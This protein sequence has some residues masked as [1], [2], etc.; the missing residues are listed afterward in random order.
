[1]II[2]AAFA[3]EPGVGLIA[4]RQGGG[5]PGRIRRI[6]RGYH[7]TLTGPRAFWALAP[8]WPSRDGGIGGESIRIII[9]WRIGRRELDCLLALWWKRMGA[10]RDSASGHT[11]YVEFSRPVLTELSFPPL[12]PSAAHMGVTC[13]CAAVQRPLDFTNRSGERLRGT[14]EIAR[15]RLTP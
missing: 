10:A 12:P 5:N 13:V 6:R 3:I 7:L 9:L 8:R 15:P 2:L 11:R 1:M 4:A 14:E